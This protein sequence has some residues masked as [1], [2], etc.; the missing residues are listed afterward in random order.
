[1]LILAGLLVAGFVCNLL[2]RPLP[3]RSAPTGPGTGPAPA[4]DHPAAAHGGSRPSE[5]QIATTDVSP[6]D[7]GLIWLVMFWLLV[8][9]PPAWGV[10]MTMRQAWV[11][12]G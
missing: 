8:A 10:W 7:G 9:V 1:M 6:P 3:N 5:A 12:L 4:D 11:L 2:V